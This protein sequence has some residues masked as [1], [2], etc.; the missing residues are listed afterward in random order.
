MV[1]MDLDAVSPDY[2]TTP[3]QRLVAHLARDLC[4]HYPHAEFDAWGLAEVLAATVVDVAR[5][6]EVEDYPARRG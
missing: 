6:L 5:G 2:A 1:G 3:G 4:R